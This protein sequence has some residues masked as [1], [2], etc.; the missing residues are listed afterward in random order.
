ML[1]VEFNQ[2]GN[3]T[4]TVRLQ[5]RL[6][7]PYAE[8]ARSALQRHPL[9]SSITVDLSEV[10]FIDSLGQQVLA[11]LG[12]LGASFLAGN[13]YTQGICESLNLRISDK[14]A[15]IATGTDPEVLQ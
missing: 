8:D 6:V 13:L 2:N 5:G 12:R 4:L 11:W 14:R 10:T 1:R 3:G 9:P 15:G 7:G